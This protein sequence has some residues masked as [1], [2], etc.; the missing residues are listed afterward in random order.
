MEKP[1]VG[2]ARDTSV[3]RDT[4]ATPSSSELAQ[5]LTAARDSTFRADPIAL[6][7]MATKMRPAPRADHDSVKQENPPPALE[8]SID[9]Q[10]D[11]ERKVPHRGRGTGIGLTALSLAALA[12]GATMHVLSLDDRNKAAA[13]K[14]F[15]E[16]SAVPGPAFDAKVRENR[17]LTNSADRKTIIAAGLA[18]IG[19][20]GFCVGIILVF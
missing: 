6:S 9:E 13:D 17:Q 20:A 18:G 5:A 12:G 7:Q 8:K 2:A 14:R 4:A 19:S 1:S 11:A 15:L 16:Q 10:M 3:A